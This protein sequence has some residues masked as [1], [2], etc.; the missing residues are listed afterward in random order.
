MAASASAGN[1]H[2]RHWSGIYAKA[3]ETKA[4]ILQYVQAA[5]DRP[6]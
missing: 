3:S 5:Q 2:Q 4:S 1:R 6:C